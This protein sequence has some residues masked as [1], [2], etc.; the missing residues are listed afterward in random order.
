MSIAGAVV[1]YAILWV[2]CFFLFLPRRIKTQKE[3]GKI[4]IGTP[5]SAPTNA[6]LKSKA[7]WTTL[8]TTIVWLIICLVLIYGNLGI[9]DI[10]IFGR[11][12]DGRYG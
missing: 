10:D 7:L 9:E 8:L 1:L 12:G 4:E 2:L 6:R 3:D 5:H 11:W